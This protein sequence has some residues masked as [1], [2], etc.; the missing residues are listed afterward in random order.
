[1]LG[2]TLGRSAPYKQLERETSAQQT[3]IASSRR[4]SVQQTRFQ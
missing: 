2:F 1:M 4:L 3:S